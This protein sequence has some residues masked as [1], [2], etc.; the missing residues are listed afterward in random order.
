MQAKLHRIERGI[1]IPPP[2]LAHGNGKPS[3]ATATMQALEKGESFLVRDPLE[4]VAADK[5]MR[6]FLR[7]ERKQKGSRL[8][9]SR[10]TAHGLRI[11]R[12]K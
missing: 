4:A 9:L 12:V 6:G 3:M 5:A 7:R 1:K 2:A 11:W 8:F 10:K